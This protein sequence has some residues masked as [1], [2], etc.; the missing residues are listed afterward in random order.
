MHQDASIEFQLI[1]VVDSLLVSPVLI[2]DKVARRVVDHDPF[3][4]G[5]VPQEAV[6]PSFGFAS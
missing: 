6:L 2:A 3:V 5:V 1:P 4:E